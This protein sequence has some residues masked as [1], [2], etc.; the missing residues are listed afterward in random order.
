VIQML[1]KERFCMGTKAGS[2][3]G[4]QT[5]GMFVS[6]W[7]ANYGMFESGSTRIVRLANI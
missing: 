2:R 6:T 4:L 1:V 3:A 5:Y 7:F